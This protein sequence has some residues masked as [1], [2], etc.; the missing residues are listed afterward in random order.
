MIQGFHQYLV[1]SPAEGVNWQTGDEGAQPSGPKRLS[2]FNGLEECRAMSA[3]HNA[4][5]EPLVQA[6]E[7]NY[8]RFVCRIHARG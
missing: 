8:I 5:V 4:P 1:I 3:F 2:I 7:L 6:D